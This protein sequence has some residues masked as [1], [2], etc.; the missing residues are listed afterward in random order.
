MAA[1]MTPPSITKTVF[2]SPHCGAFTTQHWLTLPAVYIDDKQ[3]VP[4]IPD[5]R[6]TERIKEITEIDSETMV[7]S[8]A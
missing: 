7:I 1:K 4:S 6:W 8:M 3:R 5:D 2:D